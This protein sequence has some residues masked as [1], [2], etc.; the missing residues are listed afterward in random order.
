MSFLTKLSSKI[1]LVF[2]IWTILVLIALSLLAFSFTNSI[3]ERSIMSNQLEI[4]RQT[5]DKIDRMLNERILNIQ[6]IAGAPPIQ[7]GMLPESPETFSLRKIAA[8]RIEEF[9]K[10]TGPWDLLMMVDLQGKI[11]I[12]SD[13]KLIRKQIEEMPP[14]NVAYKAIL[15]HEDFYYSDL[16][17]TAG[18]EGPGIIFAAPIYNKN[19]AGRP[20]T[21]VVIGHFSWLA[22]LQILED[23][24]VPAKIVNAEGHVIFQNAG[25]TEDLFTQYAP[26]AVHAELKDGLSKSIILDKTDSLFGTES[27][28]S[29]APQSGYLFYQGSRWGIILE[30]PVSVAWAPSREASMKLVGYLVPVILLGVVALVFFIRQSVVKPIMTL[31]RITHDIAEGDLN[32]QAPAFTSDEMGQ[33]AVSF[34]SMT[35]KL[36]KSQENLEEKVEQRTQELS[37]K[38]EQLELLQGIAM[39]VAAA[40]DLSSALEVVLRR[41]CQKTG[42]VIGQAWVPQQDDNYLKCSPAWFS[43]VP[44]M[45]AFRDYCESLTFAPGIG[46]PGRIWK[47]KE[48]VWIQDLSADKNFPRGDMALKA[49]LKAGFGIPILASGQIMAVLE[50]FMPETQEQDRGLVTIITAVAAQLGLAIERKAAEETRKKMESMM[51]QSE[52]MSAIGQLAGGVAH[53]INN[54]LGVILGFSQNVAR[55]IKPGDPLEMPIKSIE[56]EAVRCKNLVRDLLTF[57]RVEKSEKEL[58]DV[59]ETI[60][61]ALTLVLAQ[62]KVKSIDLIKEF[63]AVPKIKANRTQVQQIV[64]NLSN[65]AIDAMPVG[66]KLTLRVLK[67]KLE[68]SEAVEIQV[69][70]NGQGIPAEIQSKIFNPF[71]TTKEIGKGTGLGLSLVYEIIG[72]HDGKIFLESEVGKGTTFRVLLPT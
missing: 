40:A 5:L 61:G 51:R 29:Y 28:A 62:A 41:V 12:S 45:E 47:T 70:D 7:N 57:S 66:G 32:K 35:E 38:N 11:I 14:E 15:K 33:L 37:K 31:T 43:G 17:M 63:S 50:F 42:W 19:A 56:R 3:L 59:V 10:V 16:I 6:T 39:E 53:E 22:V 2:S 27:L 8:N 60:E 58:L 65:N 13:E 34:N 55:N 72:K 25:S 4:A 44:G 36:K 46:L 21:G 23:V 30:Q 9:T 49:G 24:P 54:P 71:F 20:M 18:S 69:Q 48:A 64:V 1:I 26:D 68:G 67:A 52:K